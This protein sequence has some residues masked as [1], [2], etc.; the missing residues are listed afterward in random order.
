M[1]ALI[2]EYK[3]L[4][5]KTRETATKKAN[6]E[7]RPI[8]TKTPGFVS[9]ELIRPDNKDDMVTSISVFDTRAHA[10]ESGRVAEEWVR[11]NLPSMTK[12]TKVTG[13]LVAH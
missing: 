13:E 9:Y 5:A 11:T 8:L 6:S 10:E 2:R 12:P 4:D 7:L 1:Y 3:G